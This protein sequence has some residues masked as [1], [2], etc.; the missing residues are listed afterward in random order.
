VACEAE[1]A[2]PLTGRK[3]GN[4]HTAHVQGSTSDQIIAE[5]NDVIYVTQNG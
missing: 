2:S 5:S 3:I 1:A 4:Y